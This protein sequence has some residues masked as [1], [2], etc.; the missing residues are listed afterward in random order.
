MQRELIETS[1]ELKLVYTI[2]YVFIRGKTQLVGESGAKWLWGKTH[3]L[4][5]C[6]TQLH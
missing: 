4:I 5:L 3:K 6:V 2:A 1:R